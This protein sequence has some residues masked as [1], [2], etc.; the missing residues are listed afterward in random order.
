MTPTPPS[1][2]EAMET[3]Q[4]EKAGLRRRMRRAREDMG[5]A[6]RERAAAA[7]LRNLLALPAFREARGVHCYLSLPGEVDTA[8]IFAACAEL[9]KETWVPFLDRSPL[10]P[11]GRLGWAPWRPGDPLVTGE[12][13]VPEP[14]AEVRETGPPPETIDL[15]LAPGLAFDRQG[16]RLGYGKGY[17][18][19]FLARLLRREKSRGGPILAGLAFALQIAAFV[20]MTARDIS[21]NWIVHESGWVEIPRIS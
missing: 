17:Y 14:L 13:G 15:V 4:G 19:E 1:N 5:Q 11:R 2:A 18:D 10:Q 21:M 20:P 6:E 8:G 7:I 16:G 3:I 12:L 9:G